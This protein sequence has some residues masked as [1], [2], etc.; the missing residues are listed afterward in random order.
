M[1][2]VAFRLHKPEDIGYAGPQSGFADAEQKLLQ[3][4]D[5]VCKVLWQRTASFSPYPQGVEWM[6]AVVRGE[7]H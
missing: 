2:V 5:V 6:I 7:H 4:R 1:L 3:E